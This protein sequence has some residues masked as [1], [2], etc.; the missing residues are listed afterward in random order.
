MATP[1]L[2]SAAAFAATAYLNAK[3]GVEND[4]KQLSHD[5]EWLIRFQQWLGTL[6][7]R[8]TLY[9]VFE[10]ADSKSEA[11]WFEDRTWTYAQLQHG[12]YSNN[13]RL[14]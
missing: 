9:H 7:D 3:L 10:L 13:E 4:L 12:E 2:L 14:E 1:A 6:G 11:L 8:C 5:R